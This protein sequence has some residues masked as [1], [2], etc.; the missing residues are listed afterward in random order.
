MLNKIIK[1]SIVGA[2]FTSSLISAE[3]DAKIKEE[4]SNL[5]IIKMSGFNIKEVRDLGDIYAIKAT[6]PRSPKIMVFASKDSKTVIFGNG[7][8]SD[9]K[10]IEFKT[11]ISQFKKD[12]VY[13]VGEGNE[14]YYVFTDPECPYCKRLEKEL[15]KL[16][17]N[18]KINFLLFPL[19]FHKNAIAMSKYILSKEGD[20][21]RALAMKEIAEGSKDYQNAKYSDIENN[22]LQAIIDRNLEIAKEIGVAGTPA[23]FAKDGTSVAWPELF[24]GISLR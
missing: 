12:V 6:H 20:K 21:A 24:D 18:I 16:K 17:K 14:E 3:V 19:N 10:K 23:A 8:T 15:P 1:L 7:F 4:L 2:V 5:K 9:G 22:R 13:S 11:D